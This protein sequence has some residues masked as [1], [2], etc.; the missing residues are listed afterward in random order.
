[1]DTAGCEVVEQNCVYHVL[2]G[3]LVG[4]LLFKMHFVASAVA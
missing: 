4:V 2:I 1:M 3:D